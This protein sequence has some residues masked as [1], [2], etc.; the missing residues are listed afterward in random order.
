MANVIPSLNPW[1][2][3][4]AFDPATA[5]HHLSPE[6][7]SSPRSRSQVDIDVV[8]LDGLRHIQVDHGEGGSQ[9]AG[10]GIVEEGLLAV[11]DL[12]QQ[13]DQHGG[14]LGGLGFDWSRLVPGHV[15]EV[16][17][18]C[19][20]DAGHRV[21]DH[22]RHLWRGQVDV[23]V[24]GVQVDG[25]GGQEPV[26]VRLGDGVG[27]DTL[28]VGGGR[29]REQRGERA[30]N[31]D[32]TLQAGDQVGYVHVFITEASVGSGSSETGPT[33]LDAVGASVVSQMKWSP[34]RSE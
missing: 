17:D 8:G 16:G 9:V 25:G 12:A 27:Q 13:F 1:E 26:Q 23:E 29:V 10:A 2:S 21:Q 15:V 24:A 22:Q 34:S 19:D 32:G 4:P 31:R 33:Q 3:N 18:A 6:L 30:G 28:E 11:A 7:R 5:Y 14:G 20:D